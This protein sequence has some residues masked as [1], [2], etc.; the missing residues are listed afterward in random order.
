M[1]E[2][3]K[4]C[5]KQI[6]N[7]KNLT[8]CQCKRGATCLTINW[9]NN[10]IGNNESFNKAKPLVVVKILASGSLDSVVNKKKSGD[11]F[12]LKENSLK[13]LER[14]CFPNNQNTNYTKIK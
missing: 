14:T 6:K 5:C 9:R 1:S 8:N 4:R 12:S 2:Q 13:I 11:M 10:G 3:T 7:R